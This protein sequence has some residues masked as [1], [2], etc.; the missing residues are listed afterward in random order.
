M[1]VAQITFLEGHGGSA[2]RKQL[3]PSGAGGIEDPS[4][5]G[6]D[7]RLPILLQPGGARIPINLYPSQLDIKALHSL[8]GNEEPV[9]HGLLQKVGGKTSST[10]K[11]LFSSS[12]GGSGSGCL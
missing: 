12:K 11:S 8:Y 6:S 3:D 1:F 4:I 9:K 2:N 7:Q 10:F 5:A